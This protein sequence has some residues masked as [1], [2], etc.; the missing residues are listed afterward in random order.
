[1]EGGRDAGPTETL[2]FTSGGAAFKGLAI[3]V[4]AA[5]AAVAVW[6]SAL[7]PALLLAAASLGSAAA[8]LS[9]RSDERMRLGRWKEARAFETLRKDVP[10]PRVLCDDL[11]CLVAANPAFR[12]MA[13]GRFVGETLDRAAPPSAGEAAEAAS[14]VYRLARAA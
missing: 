14:D 6:S 4:F 2:L 3:L 1:M 13:S 8:A 5:G 9:G 11:G 7:V 12:R 10:E